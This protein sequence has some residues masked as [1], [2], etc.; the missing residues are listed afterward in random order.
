M[1]TKVR[2]KAAGSGCPRVA[3]CYRRRALSG[4]A[5]VRTIRTRYQRMS[6]IIAGDMV[7]H[8]Q[9]IGDTAIRMASTSQGMMVLLV[10]SAGYWYSA[11]LRRQ[12][13]R[14]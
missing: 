4:R 5:T 8:L 12:G 10:F 11:W 6:H 9:L 2:G 13:R 7:Q 14:Y 3:R 1:I